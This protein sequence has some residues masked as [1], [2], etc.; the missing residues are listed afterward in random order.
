[1]RSVTQVFRDHA[2]ASVDVDVSPVYPHLSRRRGD[3]QL[4]RAIALRRGARHLVPYRVLVNLVRHVHEVGLVGDQEHHLHVVDVVG[5]NRLA[6]EDEVSGFGLLDRGHDDVVRAG[7]SEGGE[8]NDVSIV[9]EPPRSRKRDLERARALPFRRQRGGVESVI[10]SECRLRPAVDDPLRQHLHVPAVRLGGHEVCALEHYPA[11]E[12]RGIPVPE[13]RD[14]LPR[15]V[16]LL[17]PYAVLQ[18]GAILVGQADGRS[19]DLFLAA[20]FPV[21]YP[22]DTPALGR[23][24]RYRVRYRDESSLLRY[25]VAVVYVEAVHG[26]GER[27]PQGSDHLDILECSAACLYPVGDERP[28]LVYPRVRSLQVVLLRRPAPGEHHQFSVRPILPEIRPVETGRDRSAL[29]VRDGDHIRQHEAA[30]YGGGSVPEHSF[31]KLVVADRGV[32]ND[33]VLRLEVRAQQ[34]VH[35]L[36]ERGGRDLHRCVR[37]RPQGARARKVGG[38]RRRLGGQVGG[39]GRQPVGGRLGVRGVVRAGTGED[40]PSALRQHPVISAV[41]ARVDAAVL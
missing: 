20:P 23:V 12:P 8:Q 29:R 6:V 11:V 2:R 5:P 19:P 32:G 30:G 31:Q 41:G 22:D 3:R 27:V 28:V 36:P 26:D 37:V 1:M 24:A 33:V 7:T 10:L 25:V 35:R 18:E 16:Y 40:D 38:Q 13:Q 39:L 34:G 21:D 9:R 4:Q 15:Q 14:A 17:L